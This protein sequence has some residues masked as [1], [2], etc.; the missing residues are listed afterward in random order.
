[1][2]DVKLI[3]ILLIMAAAVICFDDGAAQRWCDTYE[4]CEEQN[5]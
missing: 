4:I 1:M 3:A 2:N 5:D